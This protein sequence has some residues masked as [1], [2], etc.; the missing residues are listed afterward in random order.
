MTIMQEAHLKLTNELIH[1]KLA[2]ELI[3]LKHPI[4]VNTIKFEDGSGSKFIITSKSNPNKETF[5]QL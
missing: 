3:E 5:I 1:L 2:K 4:Q